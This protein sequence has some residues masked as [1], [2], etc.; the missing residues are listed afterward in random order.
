MQLK[1][2]YAETLDDSNKAFV[3]EAMKVRMDI[4][5]HL[6]GRINKFRTLKEIIDVYKVINDSILMLKVDEADSKK[7]SGYS[8]FDAAE[9]IEKNMEEILEKQRV[10][11]L[12]DD[13]DTKQGQKNTN[14]RLR[15]V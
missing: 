12:N 14:T 10:V 5:H 7:E 9:M 3:K 2:T 4:L 13:S 11:L 6:A 1:K 15:A 8:I